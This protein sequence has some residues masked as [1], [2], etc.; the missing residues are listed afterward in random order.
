MA[1]CSHEAATKLIMAIAKGFFT[2][3]FKRTDQSV[4]VTTG[5]EFFW[6]LSTPNNADTYFKALCKLF[7]CCS[8]L[9][10]SS[11]LVKAC[12]FLVSFAMRIPLFTSWSATASRS[13]APFVMACAACSQPMSTTTASQGKAKS[14]TQIIHEFDL[15]NCIFAIPIQNND[16][17]P[18]TYPSP[19]I[20]LLSF[21]ASDC[22][23]LPQTLPQQHRVWFCRL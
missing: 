19:L 17:L 12:F 2:A 10:T 9:R 4:Q 11:K 13:L 8:L 3:R 21:S 18:C 6:E 16:P 7:A 23:T 15:K 14:R 1:T 20:K 5:L 22:A